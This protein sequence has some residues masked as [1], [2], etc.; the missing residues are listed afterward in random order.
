MA[1][2]Y[3]VTTNLD[4]SD[5][6]EL[7]FQTYLQWCAF[8]LGVNSVNGKKL[9]HPTGKYAEGISMKFNGPGVIALVSTGKISEQIEKGAP[10][11]N[12]KDKMLAKGARTSKDGSRYRYIPSGLS[13]GGKR[14]G[15][16]QNSLST[17]ESNNY[18]NSVMNGSGM[19]IEHLNAKAQQKGGVVTMSSKQGSDAWQIP[20]FPV[21]APA[22][23]YAKMARS[24]AKNYG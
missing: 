8:A 11:F 19:K 21:Y 22:K 16:G 15:M 6:S 20:A 4:Q 13:E 14:F 2:V 18:L 1:S 10:A 24:E 12:L 3:S 23:Y 5:L 7:A 17:S 9:K